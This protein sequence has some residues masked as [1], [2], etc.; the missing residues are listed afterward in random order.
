MSVVLSRKEAHMPLKLSLRPGER[1]FING[2]IVHNGERRVILAVESRARIMRQHM[3]DVEAEEGSDPLVLLF[4]SFRDAYMRDGSCPPAALDALQALCAERAFPEEH[5][6][7][8]ALRKLVPE[9]TGK[10]EGK[11]AAAPEAEPNAY[12]ALMSLFRL[13]EEGSLASRR[14]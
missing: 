13:L 2:A 9:E 12:P 1:F 5:H 4:V 14:R 11:T 7:P 10:D 8:I 3:L 6:L